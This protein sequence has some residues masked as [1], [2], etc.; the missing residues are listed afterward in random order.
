ME[1]FRLTRAFNEIRSLALSLL[2]SH[3]GIFFFQ[4]GLE[5]KLRP[6]W[7]HGLFLHSKQGGKGFVQQ[8]SGLYNV[9]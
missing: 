8:Q 3:F 4:F 7:V 1:F 9:G 6:F 5:E 2:K